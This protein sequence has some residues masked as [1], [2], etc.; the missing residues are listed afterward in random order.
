MSLEHELKAQGQ[1]LFRWRSLLPL[2]LVPVLLVS[3]RQGEVVERLLGGNADTGWKIFCA[4]VALLGLIVRCWV[5]GYAP[6]GTS[7]RNTKTQRAAELNTT[8]L[9]SLVRHPLYLGNFLMILGV[10]LAAEIWWF[11][12]LLSL[13]YAMYYERIM[14]AEESFLRAQFGQKFIQWAARTPAFFPKL[15]GYQK[16]SLSFSWK[17]VVK[18]EHTGLLVIALGFA[19]IELVQEGIVEHEPREL[20]KWLEFGLV[21]VI[22]YLVLRG[23]KKH[24]HL[25]DVAGR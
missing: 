20:L 5:T 25:L 2:I 11:V 18:R 17:H 4:T 1:W 8:G 9:Y 16:P 24:T 10:I 22:G 15:A 12:A 21:S 13:A 6:A 19:V 14:L 3:L 7:G 23:L